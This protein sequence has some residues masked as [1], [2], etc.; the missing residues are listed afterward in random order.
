MV[1][2]ELRLPYPPLLL[3]APARVTWAIHLR[4]L[5]KVL[6]DPS[7]NKLRIRL[8]DP[9]DHIVCVLLLHL[10]DEVGIEPTTFRVRT[11]CS[12]PLSYSPASSIAILPAVDAA[13]HVGGVELAAAL[14]PDQRRTVVDLD[15]G[16]SAEHSADLQPLGRE[17]AIPVDVALPHQCLL[18]CHIGRPGE[19]RTHRFHWVRASCKPTFA[20]GPL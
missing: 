13:D 15:H 10:D 1:T 7:L 14:A 16:G 2:A 3:P 19:N 12:I 5:L 8:L 4:M 18:V 11:E 20:T 6:L 9:L 17:P